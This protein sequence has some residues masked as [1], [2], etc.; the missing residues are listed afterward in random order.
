ME[1]PDKRCSR[2]AFGKAVVSLGGSAALAACAEREEVTGTATSIP[3]GRT[4]WTRPDRQH[5]WNE[6]LPTNEH[7]KRE[8]PRHH[9]F[10]YLDYTGDVPTAADRTTVEE[11]L[12]TLERAYEWSPRGLMF[13]VSYSRAYF[14]RF[15]E[16]L[17][18]SIDLPRPEPL[19][20]NESPE[21]DRQDAVLHLAS[22]V[23]KVV[24]AAEEAL[25]G[26]LDEL[27]G[28]AV[29]GDLTG[30]FQRADR[31]TGFIGAGLPA[32]KQATVD[33]MPDDGPVPEAAPEFMGFR[34]P[35]PKNQASEDFVTI[36]GGPFAG[37][38]T[39]HIERIDIDLDGWYD[40]SHEERVGLMFS[41]DHATEESVGTVGERLDDF[42][43]VTE[44]IADRLETAA[45]TH[46][47]VGHAQKTARARQDGTPVILRRDVDTVV[48]GSAG[49][50]FQSLQSRMHDFTYTRRKMSGVN[51]DRPTG[52]SIDLTEFEGIGPDENHGIL[53]YLTTTHRGN[54]LMPRRDL[55]ALPRPRPRVD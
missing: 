11:V 7:G 54:F 33:A 37:S 15:D 19:G 55:R 47:Y 43:G 25:F 5:A 1:L 40:L 16:S 41:P 36:T 49:L 35:F 17:P 14:D 30:I 8:L 12:A 26:E 28:V 51:I 38:T 10:L 53:E 20:P 21:L 34:T 46:G 52:E 42:N 50:H 32:E 22:D 27:N 9:V 4:D 23:P 44:R 18:A 39:Q 13:T 31:R 2:R 24:L 48:D 45:E 3:S 29:E 6:F